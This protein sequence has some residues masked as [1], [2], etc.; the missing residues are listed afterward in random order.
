MRFKNYKKI[1]LILVFLLF[2]TGIASFPVYPGFA[3]TE[4][5][6]RSSIEQK[7]AELEQIYEEIKEIELQMED[8]SSDKEKLVAE[9][10]RL[11][12]EANKLAGEI[13][14]LKNELNETNK[15]IKGVDQ[16]IQKTDSSIAK[17][18]NAIAKTIRDIY[19]TDSYTILEFLLSGEDISAFF[20]KTDYL[21]QLRGKLTENVFELHNDKQS[22]L[23]DKGELETVSKQI[24][25]NLKRLE[26]ANK[27]LSATKNSVQSEYNTTKQQEEYLAGIYKTKLE[28]VVALE[29]EIRK[30]EEQLHFILNR[31]AIPD[32]G[33]QILGLPL[34][35]IVVTQL[36]GKTQDSER[37]YLSGSHSGVDFRATIGTP[38]YA[39]VD[40]KVEGVGNTDE[41]CSRVSMGKWVFI[42]HSNINLAT[43]YAHLNSYVVKKGQK[44]KEGD[45]IGYSGNTGYSTGPH[46]HVTLYISEGDDGEIA[47]EV[48]KYNSLSCPGVSWYMPLAP[49]RA[50]IDFLGY[51]QKLGKSNF[52]YPNN[53]TQYWNLYSN[54]F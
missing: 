5:Q 47:A 42:R 31:E 3:A 12:A 51:T 8:V 13:K 11:Q 10:A 15:D 53:Y 34:D 22:L 35:S 17:S 36:F 50:Y 14:G 19:D 46:L 25:D 21:S 54:K 43:A 45:L 20:V 23:G 52:K 28:Q 29:A 40:G 1:S 24:L 32:I 4:G 41:A 18:N 48:K 38:I 49:T 44:V 7:E 26:E 27:K 2:F 37:L 39:V 6:I 9:L 30:F 16:S 33:S